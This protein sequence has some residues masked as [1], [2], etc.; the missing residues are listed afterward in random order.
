MVE[1]AAH[2]KG[3]TWEW[4]ESHRPPRSARQAGHLHIHPP[5]SVR[6]KNSAFAP[7][8]AQHDG[9]AT[10]TVTVTGCFKALP[11]GYR[12]ILKKYKIIQRVTAQR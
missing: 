9:N 5:V 12:D 2:R 11:L 3:G 8:F 7:I 10:V 1:R 6:T 4:A